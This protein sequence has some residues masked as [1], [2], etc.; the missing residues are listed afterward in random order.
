MTHFRNRLG[1][2]GIQAIFAV[3]I[4]MHGKTIK[5]Y[6]ISTPEVS[7]IAK[8][9]AH[10]KYEF[11]SKVS[12]ASLPGSTIVLGAFSYSGNPHDSKTLAPT[13]DAVKKITGKEFDRAIVDRGY[14]GRK[15][16]NN[17]E[18]ILPGTCKNG[19]KY[20]KRRHKHRCKLRS[21]VEA[22]ISHLKSDHRMGRN[23]LKGT[24]G[25][26]MNALLAAIGINFKLLLQ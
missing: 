23:Y 4:Q 21:A 11:G 22:T 1:P 6:S 9:K 10:K 24:V 26:E 17:T 25:A 12:I 15:K 13:L 18:I 2:Q 19:S 8:G 7:C 14:R 5:I 3:S 16:I 20:E